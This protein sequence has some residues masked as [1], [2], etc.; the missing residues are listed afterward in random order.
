M[1]TVHPRPPSWLNAGPPGPLQHPRIGP[2]GSRPSTQPQFLE[3]R[4]GGAAFLC[5]S[6][7]CPVRPL[8]KEGPPP[9]WAPEV[10]ECVPGACVLAKPSARLHSSPRA[11]LPALFGSGAPLP[12]GSPPL[13]SSQPSGL[14][15]APPQ[16]LPAPLPAGSCFHPS[17]SQDSTPTGPPAEAFILTLASRA[18]PVWGE[19]WSLAIPPLTRG[20]F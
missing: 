17:C 4:P 19:V 5:R 2:A 7:C 13:S 18:A 15:A 1:G 9:R 16:G 20:H 6:L 8:W 12:R 14:G 10:L 11:P 3:L